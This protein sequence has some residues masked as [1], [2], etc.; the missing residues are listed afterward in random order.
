MWIVFLNVGINKWM[1]SPTCYE[2][3]QAAKEAYKNRLDTVYMI[4]YIKVTSYEELQLGMI[5]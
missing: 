2:S 3:Y 1:Q 5:P 4:R